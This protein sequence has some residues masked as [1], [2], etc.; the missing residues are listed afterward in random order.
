M[1]ELKGT[2]IEPGRITRRVVT[3][4]RAADVNTKLLPGKS[5]PLVIEPMV[6]GVN[7]VNWTENH[8]QLIETHVLKYGALLFRN[9]LVNTPEKF[10]DFV[11]AISGELMDYQE[12]SSPRSEVSPGIYTSTDHPAEQTIFPHNEH[13]YALTLPLRLYFCCLR[14]ALS[15]GATPIADCR[16][17]LARLG[18][19]IT[20]K[21]QRLGW[22]YVRNFGDGFGLSW[23]TAFQTKEKALVEDYCRR[24]QIECEWKTNDR[25]RTRQVRP[26]IAEHPRTGELVW[27]NH[28]TFFHVSTLES[29]ISSVFLREFTAP[30]LPNNTYYGDGSAIEPDVLDKLRR[31]YL[32]EI[33]PFDWQRGDVLLIDNML[34]AHS[35][36]SFTGQR[37]VLVAMAEP[38]TRK[39]ATYS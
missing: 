16:K 24:A 21:F 33:V 4:E 14:P 13:S 1:S 27:F 35:R 28:A 32:D 8:R 12:R 39:D 36:E 18:S 10:S 31:A 19:N 7:A 30:D 6:R 17:V 15:G 38:F 37:K 34:T 5:I 9:F 11:K 25:L 29:R 23:Q 20:E 3:S 22:M 2:G 26:A